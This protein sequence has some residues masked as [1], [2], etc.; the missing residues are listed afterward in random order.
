VSTEADFAVLAR[1]CVTYPDAEIYVLVDNLELAH[2]L[3]ERLRAAGRGVQVSVLVELAALGRRTGV[4]GCQ[5]VVDLAARLV[6]SC[7]NLRVAGVEGYEG[8]I[9]D[10]SPEREAEL[11]DEYLSELAATAVAVRKL[12]PDERPVVVSAGGSM[13]F[14]RV[15]DHLAECGTGIDIV[16]R[17]GGYV[18]H[19]SLMYERTSPWGSERASS[20]GPRLRPALSVWASVLSHIDDR[21][22]VVGMG[23]RDAP[24]D[25][26]LPVL[27]NDDDS[28]LPGPGPGTVTSL[29]DH[30]AVVEL[31]AGSAPAA[32]ATI[33]FGISHPCTAFQ[34]WPV[35]PTIDAEGAILG[36][37]QTFF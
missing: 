34:R 13:Y 18:T 12:L 14:D 22:L 29:Y 35:I 25:C 33:S 31:S 5:R 19:D 8:V 11:V 36:A 1:E 3:D 23:R 7:R 17:P 6:D 10:E 4:A 32:G 27:D 26:G 28:L 37:V 2:T 21:Q 20:D 16:I 15:V 9:H 24:D 30:H